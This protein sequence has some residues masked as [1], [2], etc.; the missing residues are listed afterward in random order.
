MSTMTDMPRVSRHQR[1][2]TVTMDKKLKAEWLAALR[3]GKYK[4]GQGG[5]HNPDGDT[6]CC[7]GV[8]CDVARIKGIMVEI[9]R[10]SSESQFTKFVYRA[11]KWVFFRKR[12]PS[13]D[14]RDYNNTNLPVNFAREVGIASS[15]QSMLIS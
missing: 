3:S 10:G 12:T 15:D 5:L 4:Q 13:G 8:L 11:K 7:L 2:D 9:P 14:S 1:M 6:Y